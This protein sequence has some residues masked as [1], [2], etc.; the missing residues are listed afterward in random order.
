[1]TI[2]VLDIQWVA[3]S[4]TNGVVRASAG[5]INASPHT[6]SPQVLVMCGTEKVQ[7]VELEFSYDTTGIDYSGVKAPTFVTT[8][9]NEQGQ[10]VP[11]FV[12]TLKV[13]T[14]INGLAS[15]PV[16]SS[17]LISAPEL[18]V[19]LGS[20]E[21]LQVNCDFAPPQ[22]LRRFGVRDYMEQLDS[23][24]LF[25]DGTLL[26]GAN[27]ITPAKVFLKFRRVPDDQNKPI[28]QRYFFV[29][30]DVDGD[31]E[32]DDTNGDGQLNEGDMVPNETLDA[33][34]DGAVMPDE[35]EAGRVRRPLSDDG[36]WDFVG[37][38]II[39]VRI[40]D[41][42]R[43]DQVSVPPSEFAEYASLLSSSDQ[44]VP[45][46]DVTTVSVDGGASVRIKSLGRITELLP[47]K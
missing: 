32:W 24:W 45:F 30:L 34:G 20:D 19:K 2:K 39:R 40:V 15:A 12:P 1:M 22:M 33:N 9:V 47:V 38:H 16:L 44:L 7:G 4:L 11:D 14:D 31:G 28:D 27:Q 10:T 8:R 41:V 6:A 36:N 43:H 29:P 23:G 21:A 13:T 17:D 46:V 26:S 3:A 5:A 42:I 18:L 35:R 25:N 37:N